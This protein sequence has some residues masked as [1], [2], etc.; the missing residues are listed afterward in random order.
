MR[1]SSTAS[2][3]IEELRKI[4]TAKEKDQE[5]KNVERRILI[6]KKNNPITTSIYTKNCPAWQRLPMKLAC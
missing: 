6:F 2:G 1:P 3:S 5:L 4:N